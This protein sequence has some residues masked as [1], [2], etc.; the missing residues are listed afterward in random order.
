MCSVII[1]IDSPYNIK[2]FPSDNAKLAEME[3]Y[4]VGDLEC[5]LVVFHPYRTLL[6][7]VCKKEANAGNRNDSSALMDAEEGEADEMGIGIG[8]EEGRRY[9]GTGQGK[10]ELSTG[11]L[12]TAWYVQGLLFPIE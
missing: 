6:A 8:A 3:F 10:L 1:P 4:L 2:N 12:Q 11:A 5:D 9:W 7:L